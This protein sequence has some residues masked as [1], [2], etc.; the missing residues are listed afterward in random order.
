MILP[1]GLLD[2]LPVVVLA[3]ITAVFG[4]GR[5]TRVIVYDDFPPAV[6]W[7]I[8]WSKWT[9]DSAWTKLFTCYWCLSPWIMLAC[10][11]WWYVG[12]YVLWITIAWW[13]FWGWLALSYIAAII[14]AH[15]ERD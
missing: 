7:R 11:A 14:I 1:L 10:L 8:R 9:H 4:V 5:L 12:L 15:D 2:D 13:I 3:I 6:W